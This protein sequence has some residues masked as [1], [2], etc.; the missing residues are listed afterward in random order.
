MAEASNDG[1]RSS[2]SVFISYARSDADVA[3]ELATRL[4]AAGIGVWRDSHVAPG[5]NWA[6][7]IEGQLRAADYLII[8][9]T[10]AALASDWVMAETSEAI[11]EYSDRAVTVVPVLLENVEMPLSL[12]RIQYLDFRGDKQRAMDAL[13]SHLSASV[14]IDLSEFTP[15]SFE[16]LVGDLLVDLGFTV[17]REPRVHGKQFDFRAS[18]PVR[19]PFG[20]LATEQ[21][22][23]EAKHHSSGRVSVQT[24]RE[25]IGFARSINALENTKLALIT[26]GQLTS[27]GREILK[28]THLRVVEGVELKRILLTRHHLVAKHA[29]RRLK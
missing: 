7:A 11:R 16:D 28:S 25:F 2:P 15:Q 22:L 8:L 20:A 26:S 29:D 3:A 10:H 23:I 27:A 14:D 19:D 9:V 21:W 5:E 18:V 17:E 6:A 13:V 4:E 1:S 24:I 12:S